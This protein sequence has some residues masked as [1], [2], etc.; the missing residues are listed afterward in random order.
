MAPSAFGSMPSATPRGAHLISNFTMAAVIISAAR[1]AVGSFGG[2]LAK[3]SAP[4]LGAAVI[5]KVLDG[6]DGSKVD[7][8]IMG[9]VLTAG[10]GTLTPAEPEALSPRSLALSLSRSLPAPR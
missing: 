9:N 3:V 7:E 1:T 4:A 2:S 10:L 5:K 6:H 8:V